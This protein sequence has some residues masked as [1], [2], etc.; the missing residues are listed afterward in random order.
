MK[1]HFGDEK[2]EQRFYTMLTH[3]QTSS[4]DREREAMFFIISGNQELY[5][6]STL[7]YN[8]QAHRLRPNALNKLDYMCSSSKKLLRLALHLYNNCNLIE[9]TPYSLLNNLD[10]ENLSLALNGMLLR[11]S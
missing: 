11:F 3:D 1:C 10:S 2:H 4:G 9:L 7:I 8:Y 5:E 6:H